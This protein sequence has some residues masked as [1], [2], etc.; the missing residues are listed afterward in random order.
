MEEKKSRTTERQIVATST[1]L[2]LSKERRKGEM[3]ECGL[4]VVEGEL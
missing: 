3:D 4:G 2:V 1:L